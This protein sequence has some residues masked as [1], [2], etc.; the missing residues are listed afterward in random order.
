MIG[1][2]LRF[3]FSLSTILSIAIGS[4]ISTAI[5]FL[6]KGGGQGAFIVIWIISAIGLKT[7]YLLYRGSSKTLADQAEMEARSGTS[8]GKIVVRLLVTVTIVVA[9]LIFIGRYLR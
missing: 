1:S 6:L 9:A 2:L 5:I 3:I 4:I 8:S 7:A